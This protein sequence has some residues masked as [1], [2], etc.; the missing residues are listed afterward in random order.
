MYL[1]SSLYYH[2]ILLTF[3]ELRDCHKKIKDVHKPQQL[4]NEEKKS[5]TVKFSTDNNTDIFY[6]MPLNYSEKGHQHLCFDSANSGSSFFF[7]KNPFHTQRFCV[8]EEKWS[9]FT[10]DGEISFSGA[11]AF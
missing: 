7:Q 5:Q 6:Y 1:W 4:G 8:Q 2:A 9:G 11:A 10:Q 3:Y